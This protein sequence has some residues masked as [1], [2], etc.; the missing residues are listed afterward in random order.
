MVVTPHFAF[1]FERVNG[2]A[3]TVEQDTVEH[4]MSCENVIV[5]CPVGFRVERP[6]FG[7]PW[8]EYRQDVQPGEIEAAMRR[9]E[10]RSNLRAS[11]IRSLLDASQSE[12][13]IEV[14]T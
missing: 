12:I 9:F 2:K 1:P 6:E 3:M 14:E 5:R 10:P 13:T 7:I 4:V 11:E 8:P